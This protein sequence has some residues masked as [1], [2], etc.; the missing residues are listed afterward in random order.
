MTKFIYVLVIIFISSNRLGQSENINENYNDIPKS[1]WK[2]HKELDENGNVIRYDSIYSYSS[3]GKHYDLPEINSDIFSDFFDSE[4]IENK[5]FF[6]KRKFS[7]PQKQDPF[8]NDS[9][10]IDD[11]F[12]NNFSSI[13]KLMEQIFMKQKNIKNSKTT[14]VIQQ[15]I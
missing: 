11:F 1:Q 4:I 13:N 8:F 15:Q 6:K 7:N 3:S 9:F 2:V 14:K 12:R 5:A 10:Y